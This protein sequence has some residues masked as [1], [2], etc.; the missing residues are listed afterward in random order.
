MNRDSDLIAI[1]YILGIFLAVIVVM[2]AFFF[3]G[4]GAGIALLVLSMVAIAYAA[5]RGLSAGADE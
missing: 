5:I 4:S 3:I 1:P 2:A